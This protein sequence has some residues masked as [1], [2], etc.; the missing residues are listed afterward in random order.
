[1]Y[2][3]IQKRIIYVWHIK[4]LA[5]LSW[6]NGSAAA[7][8]YNKALDKEAKTLDYAAHLKNTIEMFKTKQKTNGNNDWQANIDVIF[9][10]EYE[11]IKHFVQKILTYRYNIAYNAFKMV[12]RFT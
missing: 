5:S 3:I 7:G 8:D 6:C 2:I 10:G 9:R 1:M 12:K 11:L 4:K